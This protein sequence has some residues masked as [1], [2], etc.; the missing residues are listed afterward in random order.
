[1]RAF[2]VWPR[3][4]AGRTALVLLLA[5]TLAQGA[6][7]LIHALDRVDLQRFAQ[8]REIAGRAFGLWRLVLTSPPERREAAVAEADLPQ[9]LS[10]SLDDEPLVRPGMPPPPVAAMRL[11][12]LEGLASG[13][14]PRMRA[15]EARV[16]GLGGPFE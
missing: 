3:S 5:L 2:R 10:A 15:R 1:M 7:L 6:G 14:P 13:G 9:G 16:A 11:F 8:S 4:L 12:R